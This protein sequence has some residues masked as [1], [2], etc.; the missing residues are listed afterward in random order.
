MTLSD[1]QGHLSYLCLIISVTFFRSLIESIGDLT[2]DDI[3]GD[4]EWPL[5]VISGTLQIWNISTT[6][7]SVSLCYN[8]LSSCWQLQNM[9]VGAILTQ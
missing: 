7:R 8:S 2:N 9:L 3:A 1:L 5:K 4:L 6:R